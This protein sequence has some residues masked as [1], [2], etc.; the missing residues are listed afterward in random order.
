MKRIVCTFLCC[1]IILIGSMIEVE[2]SESKE[3]RGVWVTTIYNQ[4]WPSV[5]SRNNEQLQKNEIIQI[6]EQVKDTGLN[7]IM[8]QVRPTADALYKSNINPWSDVLT[9][10]QGKDP[11][12]DPLEFIIEEAHKRGIEV[13]GWLNPYR[14]TTSG[15]DLNKL[16]PNH[17]ARLNPYTVMEYEKKLYYNPGLPAVRQHIVDTVAEIVRNYDVDGIHF[18]DYFYPGS[19]IDDSSAYALYGGGKNIGDFRRDSVN[20]MVKSVYETVKSIKPKVEFGI[21]PR[22]IWKNKSSDPTGSDT[23]GGQSYHDIYADTRTWIKN[24]WLDYVAPQIYWQIGYN[25]ADYAKLVPWWSN[26]V[27]GTKVKLYIGQAIYRQ[28]VAVEMDQQINLNRNYS[29]VKGSIHFSYRDIKNNTQR[30]RERLKN[31]YSH[32]ALPASDIN[33]KGIAYQGHL[34]D[35]GWQG[36]KYNGELSGTTDQSKRLESIM[37]TINND[38]KDA[39]VLYRTHIQDIGW[40]DWKQNGE[41]SGTV[42]LSKRIEGIEIKLENA[43]GYSVEYRIY[44]EGLGW[45]EWRRDGETAGTE[46]QSKRLEAL[47][48]RLVNK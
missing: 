15:T 44:V 18:D 30:V 20:Q 36:W 29:N 46:G 24:G 5:G 40:Q 23:K 21:S 47:E 35:I 32:F 48:I 34:Q 38:L 6:L 33:V 9:G 7:A 14:I 12:Y 26:E 11:G 13:H 42:G 43:P 17:F 2:A 3:M 19:K 31:L 25:I 10:V 1:F 4:D 16:A 41:L 22:G 8:I 45:Q 37:L 27:E 28:T 39:N